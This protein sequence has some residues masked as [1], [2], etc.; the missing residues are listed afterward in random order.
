MFILYQVA[1]SVSPTGDF[2]GPE[3]SALW[4]IHNADEPYIIARPAQWPTTFAQ[5]MSMGHP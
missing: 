4:G 5:F 3:D 1:V 2:D